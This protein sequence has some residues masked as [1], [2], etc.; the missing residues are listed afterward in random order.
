MLESLD[1]EQA[2]KTEIKDRIAKSIVPNNPELTPPSA[3]DEFLYANG[4]PL[5]LPWNGP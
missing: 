5:F 3:R 1:A 2:A 4:C